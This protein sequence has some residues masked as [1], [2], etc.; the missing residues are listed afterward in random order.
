MDRST[1]YRRLGPVG[2]II[3]R[4]L[5][6]WQVKRRPFRCVHAMTWVSQHGTCLHRVDGQMK[7]GPSP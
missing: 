6:W 4:V 1:W 2:K 5:W 3:E 7:A